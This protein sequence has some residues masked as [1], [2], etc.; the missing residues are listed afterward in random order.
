M[1]DQDSAQN[2][3]TTDMVGS[4]SAVVPVAGLY[5]Y[6]AIQAYIAKN[7]I[8]NEIIDENAKVVVLNGTQI[9][10][11][12]AEQKTKL[13]KENYN[14]VEIDSAPT[15]DYKTTKIFAINSE[16]SATI[17]K[18]ESKFGVSSSSSLPSE[19]SK[20]KQSADIVIVLG[21]E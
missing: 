13:V 12:A 18:L 11:L 20:Y 15:Q 6:S 8:S 14:I 4:A 3:L 1:N 19:F 16:K 17:K 7:T 21:E 2:L 9:S 10:G 5:D